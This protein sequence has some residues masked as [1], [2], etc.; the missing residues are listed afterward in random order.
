[1][2]MLF[3][4]G[5]TWVVTFR[6]GVR[7]VDRAGTEGWALACRATELTWSDTGWAEIQV[8]EFLIAGQWKK[9]RIVS[10]D[11]QRVIRVH[12]SNIA[13]VE[14]EPTKEPDDE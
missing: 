1:M 11:P 6:H 10:D 8:S 14:F 13:S 12:E 9:T 4:P 2:A 5:G 3:E 7:G